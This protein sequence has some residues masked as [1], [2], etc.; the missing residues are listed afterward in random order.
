MG[1][2]PVKLDKYA[3]KRSILRNGSAARR[4]ERRRIIT[5]QI[6]ADE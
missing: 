1:S 5:K 6:E 2:L 3:R 4:E